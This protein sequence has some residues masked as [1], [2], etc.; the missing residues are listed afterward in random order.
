MSG[1]PYAAVFPPVHDS[2]MLPATLV[3]QLT[4][5]TQGAPI[6]LH[7][8]N[9]RDA[10][11]PPVLKDVQGRHAT[12]APRRC[13]SAPT[14]HRTDATLHGPHTAHRCTAAHHRTTAPHL[15]LGLALASGL[16]Q[17][18]DL[19]VSVN[20]VEVTDHTAAAA[21]IRAAPDR[22]VLRLR[23]PPPRLSEPSVLH[24]ATR[25]A[26]LVGMARA[27]ELHGVES[28]DV[29]D[30][31]GWSALHAA[32]QGTSTEAVRLLLDRGADVHA[33]TDIQA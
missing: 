29:A 12:A 4:K 17:P 14:P 15:T 8:V 13:P 16:L 5:P 19:L 30:G 1:A 32:S 21:L 3:V 10:S 6:G 27:L 23:R 7:L 31:S 33:R 25:A 22:L 20:E 2:E 11:S 26:D 9:G 28:V 24:D 18:G